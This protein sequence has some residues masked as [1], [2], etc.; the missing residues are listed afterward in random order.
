M[1]STLADLRVE[2]L[3]FIF[4]DR[5]GWVYFATQE[6]FDRTTFRQFFFDWPNQ[7]GEISTWLDMSAQTKNVWFCVS[8]LAEKKA[9]KDNCLPGNIVWADLDEAKPDQIEPR[10]QVVIESSPNRWQS[11]WRLDQTI[12]PYQAEEYSRRLAYMLDA[13][14]SGWDMTQLLR[15]PFTKNMKYEDT[16]EVKLVHAYT[17]TLPMEIFESLPTVPQSVPDPIETNYPLPK[18]ETLQD[19]TSIG[20]KYAS[21]FRE[22]GLTELLNRTPADSEDWSVSLWRILNLA[23][24]AGCSREEVLSLAVVSGY[25]KYERDGRDITYLWRDVCKAEIKQR[26]IELLLGD[27]EDR[28]LV[29]PELV[30]ASK[31]GRT[32]IDD[33]CEWA[34]E[35]TDAVKAFHPLCAFMILSSLLAGNIKLEASYGTVRPHLW[36]M[37]LGNSTL[38]RKTTAMNLAAAF[39]TQLDRELIV[40][41]DGSAEGILTG[42]ST[43]SGQ[44]SIFYKDEVTGLFDSIK[45]KEYLTGLPEIFT[46]LYDCPPYYTRRLR[47]ETITVNSPLF[48]CFMGGIRDKMYEL[49]DDQMILS[50]FMPRFLIVSGDADIKTIRTTGPP[51]PTNFVQR[52]ELMT[53]FANLWETYHRTEK[54]EILGQMTAQDQM[55]EVI[56]TDEAWT[57][58]SEVEIKMAEAAQ[59]TNEQMLSIPTFERLSRS[60]LKMACLLSAARQVPQERYVQCTLEDMQQAAKYMQAWGEHSIDLIQNCGHT[61]AQR[62]LSKILAYITGKPGVLRGEIMRHFHLS[63]RDMTEIQK[64]LE[65][66]GQVLISKE[67]KAIKFTA[68]GV[69]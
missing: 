23:F 22:T 10:P 11:I 28:G 32:I 46:N 30:D 4:A 69:L 56:L 68:V 67:G 35:A 40:A 55:F 12:Q 34:E 63:S 50:G 15:V 20:Y 33:Y 3:D 27:T 51:S 8:Q 25:N 39:I 37:I 54:V 65:E 26:R 66:R 62:T 17:P 52:A 48:M 47:K 58:N 57:F 29:M 53:K 49:I 16:P 13:D 21:H 19:P 31:L 38:S 61:V 1:S 44:V 43:R 14:K 5:P 60:M 9:S 6:P 2:F 64:T 24:E 59:N 42:L 18:L 36:G 45:K 41:S 7:R